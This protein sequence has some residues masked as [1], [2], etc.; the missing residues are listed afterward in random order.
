MYMKNR[1][2]D[3]GVGKFGRF[4]D[5]AIAAGRQEALVIAC[6]GAA[7]T[8]VLVLMGLLGLALKKNEKT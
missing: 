2:L 3:Q 1:S 4:S 5:E 8:V 7:G 6:V